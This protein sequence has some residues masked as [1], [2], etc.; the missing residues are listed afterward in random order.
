MLSRLV[1]YVRG[2]ARRRQVGSEVDDE[3]RFHVEQ[4]IQANVAR[5]MSPAEARR[6][7]L[8]DLGGLTQ[9]REA[10]HEVRMTWL[11][12]LWRD[13]RYA[14]RSLRATPSFTVVAVLVLT[15]GI[16]ATTAVFSVVD[17]V[18]L[19]RLP[20][21]EADRLVA[22]GEV[23]VK[24]DSEWGANLVAPQN[25]LDWRAR[26]DVFSG[27][28]AIGYASISLRPAEQKEPEVLTSL[29]V[30]A[31]FFPVLGVKP[32][33]GRTFTIDNEVDG[34]ARVAVISYRLWQRRFGGSPDVLGQRLPGQ[35]G[36]FEILGVMPPAFAYPVGAKRPTEVWLPY[37][38]PPEHRIRGSDFSYYLRVIAR[39]QPG[40]SLQRA[41]A[42][43]D[44]ITAEL[45][46]ETPR[47]FEDRVAR[48][49]RLGDYLTKQV[50]TWMFMLLGAVAFVLLIACVNLS[51]LTLARIST[52]NRELGI[53][54]ALGASRWDLARAL[55]VENLMLSLLGAALGVLVAWLGID[56]LRAAMPAELPRVATIAIDG[57][58][59]AV[60]VIMAV[61]TGLAF[62]AVPVFQFS[63]PAARP[64]LTQAG[65]LSTATPSQQWLRATLVVAEV[66]LAVVLLVGSC[67]FLASF[68]RFTS[69]NLGIDYH[70]VLTVRIR[71][72]VGPREKDVALQRNPALLRS[73]LERVRAIP[74][75]EVASLIG[76]GEMVPLSG[77][78]ITKDFGVP[79]RQVSPLDIDFTEISPDYFRAIRVP[80]L[81]GRF[82]A[83]TDRQGSEPVAIC[84]DAAAKHYFPGEDPIDKLVRLQGTRTVVGIVGNIRHDGPEAGWRKHSTSRERHRTLRGRPRR[85]SRSFVP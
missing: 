54:S 60:A 19:R 68:A 37:V 63:R 48:V 41:Q 71:P 20:F 58:V 36:D 6:I 83:G 64:A 15:L 49:E 53:R 33:I 4:E 51:N 70:D 79:G 7:A 9:T 56:L 8:R 30:T 40:V 21:P 44:Q 25:F 31:D 18:I 42:R 82:F 81:R 47:W 2:I 76:G 74:G 85:S 29:A 22:V 26:Q 75:I 73:V 50:R 13:A 38:V 17:A 80:L 5:G 57:R 62:S 65:R 16:G 24:G 23:N 72:L 78:L 77:N 35:L 59:L 14:A 39:L 28:A 67:W 55:L 84:N 34:N 10:I 52:R 11:D 1:S 46:S 45:E 12:A 27:L 32:L 61:V 3:R 66:A 43:M 69:V